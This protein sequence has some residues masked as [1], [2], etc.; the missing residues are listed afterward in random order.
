LG[1][2]IFRA[3]LTFSS[4]WRLFV[5]AAMF[6]NKLF[7]GPVE[8]AANEFGLAQDTLRKALAKASVACGVDGCFS[9]AEICRGVFGGLAEEKLLTQRQLTR[10]Y[11][12]ENQITEGSLL[13]KA[14]LSAG[15][16]TARVA[17]GIAD[18]RQNLLVRVKCAVRNLSAFPILL[19]RNLIHV[20][21]E[22]RSEALACYGSRAGQTFVLGRIDP[23][24]HWPDDQP[25]LALQA[26]PLFIG[27]ARGGSCTVD[28]LPIQG[29]KNHQFIGHLYR[30]NAGG[31]AVAGSAIYENIVVM[32]AEFLPYRPQKYPA[33][34][35]W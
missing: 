20:L 21:L 12:L 4:L 10:K 34:Q 31:I 33:A 25:R 7:A 26:T 5:L 6:L 29:E 16:Q 32:F 2:S 15:Q 35:V 17:R 22:K 8:R 19:L 14:A 3:K 28:T 27:G 13:N 1:F 23:R 30:A 9:T 11:Q 18:R 24:H